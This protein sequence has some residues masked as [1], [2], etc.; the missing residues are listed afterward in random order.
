MQTFTRGRL[1]PRQPQAIKGTTRTELR[2]CDIRNSGC[3]HWNI[4]PFCHLFIRM[5]V[6]IIL[7]NKRFN[8]VGVTLSKRNP[9]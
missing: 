5:F 3:I 9:P 6:L 7:L 1:V 4:A 8:A 2:G